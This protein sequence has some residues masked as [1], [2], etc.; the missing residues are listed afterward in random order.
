MQLHIVQK[1]L[2]ETYGVTI[3][4][5]ITALPT[6]PTNAIRAV[7]QVETAAVRVQFNKT[8]S[9]TGGVGGGYKVNI[10]ADIVVDDRDSL[11]YMR[12]YRDAT[13]DAYIN[14]IYFGEGERYA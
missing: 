9:V 5:T 11:N 6:V 4:N 8:S 3:S 2:G 1:V 14:V 12:L 10:G 13:T 7:I